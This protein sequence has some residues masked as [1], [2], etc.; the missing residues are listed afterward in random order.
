MAAY[1]ALLEPGDTILAMELSQGGHLTHGSPVNF[2]GKLFNFIHYG[3]D[4]KTGFIDLEEVRKLAVEHKPKMIV[5]GFTAYPRNVDFK[6]FQKI[7]DE[8]SALLQLKYIDCDSCT[9]SF[10]LSICKTTHNSFN[11]ENIII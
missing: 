3:V 5:C 6:G 11:E 2:S 7:A 10:H 9:R 8:V 1:F 4:E